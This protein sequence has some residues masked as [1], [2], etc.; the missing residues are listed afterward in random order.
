MW[1]AERVI[2][3]NG[4]DFE[5]LY[6]EYFASSGLTRCK[7]QMMRTKPQ[8]SG[9]ELGP[10]L[11]GG[12]TFRFYPSFRICSTLPALRSRIAEETPEYD[13]FGIHTMV[14]QTTGGELTLGDSHDY[15]L[16]PTIFNREQ[17]D[18]LI[19]QHLKSFLRVPDLSVAERWY[20]VYAKHFD[21]PYLRFEPE[22][23]VEVVTGLGGAGMTLSFGVAAETF[24][25]RATGGAA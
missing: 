2:V 24:G 7:L 1:Q 11:A 10:S 13:R 9:W 14:S 3:C 19:L 17:I 20:G 4:S 8:A 25:L 15:G 16:T 5:T 23:G 22:S 6:P 12:L 18:D 21:K